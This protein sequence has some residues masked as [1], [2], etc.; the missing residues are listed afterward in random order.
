M[1]LHSG[2]IP[3][4]RT[5]SMLFVL[6]MLIEK[7]PWQR[8][9]HFCLNS[10]CETYFIYPLGGWVPTEI[11][12]LMLVNY[13]ITLWRTAIELKGNEAIFSKG[14]IKKSHLYQEDEDL[15]L[16]VWKEVWEQKSHSFFSKY[17]AFFLSLHPNPHSALSCANL[18]L[19]ISSHWPSLI[20]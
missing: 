2:Y 17:V 19:H 13:P 9:G 7:V 15:H 10:G 1:T 6:L 5:E 11:I 8:N 18:I 3:F 4:S 14:C 12:W 16:T 20:P